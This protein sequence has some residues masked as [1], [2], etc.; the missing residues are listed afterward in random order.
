MYA[1]DQYDA[2]EIRT[3]PSS[4]ERIFAPFWV[5]IEMLREEIW[6]HHKWM[7]DFFEEYYQCPKIYKPKEF[8]IPQYAAA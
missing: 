1:V 8:S 3:A 6:K 5:P 4:S 7:I 2:S